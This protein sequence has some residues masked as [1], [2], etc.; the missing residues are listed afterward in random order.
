MQPRGIG[1]LAE[2]AGMRISL[3]RARSVFALNVEISRPCKFRHAPGSFNRNKMVKRAVGHVV[4][5]IQRS[6]LR[7]LRCANYTILFLK[8]VQH[9]NQSV[10]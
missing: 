7:P 1:K 10:V 6:F 9:S 8:V 3:N 2:M 4:A 5:A